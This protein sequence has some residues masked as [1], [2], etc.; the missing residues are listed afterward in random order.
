MKKITIIAA[1]A[2]ALMMPTAAMAQNDSRAEGKTRVKK[3]QKVKEIK[4]EA[5]SIPESQPLKNKRAEREE[6]FIAGLKAMKV[7][8]LRPQPNFTITDLKRA[9]ENNLFVLKGETYLIDNVNGDSYLAAGKGGEAE[10]VYDPA[11]PAATIA[12]MVVIGGGYRAM[13]DLTVAKHR[14]G[15]LEQ[16]Q[17]PLEA[18]LQYCI[19][20]GCK[21]YWGLKSVAEN[22]LEGTIF[23]YNAAKG[24]DHV[25][26][27]EC[28][29]SLLGDESFTMKAHAS[30]F[31]PTNNVKDLF[32]EYHKKTDNE[33]IKWE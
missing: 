16:F 32:E 18:L 6:A 14:I 25:V 9:G 5:D 27:I 1:I 15:E 19:N 8:S 17:M 13:L 10:F 3:E 2:G 28:Y 21:V 26:R 29:P 22:K 12:N 31:I 4:R 24:Y 20:E 7:D 23:F 11:L 33:R 30:L